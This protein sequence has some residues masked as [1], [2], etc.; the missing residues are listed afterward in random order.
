[1]RR[2]AVVAIVAG[3]AALAGRSAIAADTGPA[4]T[5]IHFTQQATRDMAPDRLRAVMRFQAKG[6]NPRQLQAEINRRMTAALDKA[7][8]R[9]GVTAATG[10]YVVSRDYSISD[11]RNAWIGS[12][13]LTLS[14][15][16]FD[17]VLALVGELQGDGLLISG[18][19]FYLAPETLKSLER[20]LT[21]AALVGLKARA[22]DVA[23]DLGMSVDRYKTIDVGNA[24]V[25][26]G[27]MLLRGMASTAAAAPAMPP[28]AAQPGDETVSLSVTADV[29]LAPAKP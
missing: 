1:M 6:S 15:K 18:L 28:P 3:I 19:Q 8:G 21:A 2:I 12:E 7:K 10:A 4:G 23:K 11:S 25:P 16:D 24:I 14:S 13:S 29:V 5:E 26:S 27:P 22:E 9:A 17:A 20:D